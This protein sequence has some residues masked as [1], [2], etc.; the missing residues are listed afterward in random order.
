MRNY[1]KVWTK[2]GAHHFAFFDDTSET[3]TKAAFDRL[4]NLRA[5]VG[6]KFAVFRLPRCDGQ[7]CQLP[8][9]GH[10]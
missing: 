6:G 2:S 5:Q 4:A 3:E 9:V 8:A 1:F 7:W 10:G